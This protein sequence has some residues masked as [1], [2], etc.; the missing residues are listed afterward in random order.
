[1][2]KLLSD[3]LKDSN[4]V[5][6][7]AEVNF[8]RQI[9]WTD[10]IVHKQT[11]EKLTKVCHSYTD[12]FSKHAT[13]VGKTDLVQMTFKWKGDIKPLDQ[14][15]YTLVLQHHTWLK[16]ELTELERAG[17]ITPSTW[18]FERSVI[19]VPKKK[20]PLIHEISYKW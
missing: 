14:N 8:H 18:D 3:T 7:P 9:K 19:M 6:S 13:D 20:E 1:M 16:Q 11:K 17:I 12:I 10:T 4:I 5:T 15:H 2:I